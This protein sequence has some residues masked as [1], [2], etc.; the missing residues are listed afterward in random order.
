L[1]RSKDIKFA[2]ALTVL[3]LA[4]ASVQS[5]SFFRHEYALTA[6]GS[7]YVLDVLV[8]INY[9]G[10]YGVV[11]V[12]LKPEGVYAY[13]FT[14]L[15]D[16]DEPKPHLY[17]MLGP[18]NAWYDMGLLNESTIR[19]RLAID[20]SNNT[21]LIVADDKVQHYTLQY[22]PSITSLY[23]SVFNITGSEASYPQ[24]DIEFIRIYATNSSL[25]EIEDIVKD[26]KSAELGLLALSIENKVIEPPRKTS[27]TPTTTSPTEKPT[28]TTPV[29]PQ[30]PAITPEDTMFVVVLV[31]ALSALI[32]VVLVAYLWGRGSPGP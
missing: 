31:I 29:S 21:A 19:M 23:L 27:P 17:L 13:G 28:P 3:A 16:P 14:I 5:Y 18:Q 2:I 32:A 10:N 6:R 24:I 22:A 4:L 9:I 1:I 12:Y 8:S 30:L 25:G 11:S 20:S 15:K 7:T 26:L